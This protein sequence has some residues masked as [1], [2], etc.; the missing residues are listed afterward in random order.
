[1][2]IGF[3]FYG[4]AYGPGKGGDRDF[5]HCWPNIKN[6]LVDPFIV[7]GH[8]VKLYFST[9]P[10]PSGDIRQEFN[11]LVGPNE[12]YY[13]N[14]EG[15]DA[16]TTKFATFNLIENADVDVVII[17]RIDVHYSKVIACSPY[18]FSKFNFLFSEENWWYNH[19]FT[20][21]NFYMFPKSMTESV[22]KAMQETYCYPRGRPYVDTHGLFDKLVN[23]IPV[24]AM[25]FI[26]KTHETSDVNSFYTC[27]R[28]G[29]PEDGRG[30]HIHIEVKERYGYR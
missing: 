23:Y 11:S 3:F 15:S 4:I 29:L 21:D 9:Y 14:A 22:K 25:N 7:Q 26:S 16:F 27:C 19:R 1:M 10:F 20:C 28:A 13:S 18:D 6:M 24:T 5:H 8:D 30:G 12:I 2:R 17:S